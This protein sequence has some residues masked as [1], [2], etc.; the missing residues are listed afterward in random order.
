MLKQ[1]IIIIILIS[2]INC[3]SALSTHSFT[4]K[5]NRGSHPSTIFYS[6]N[7][8]IIDLSAING[9]TAQRAIF[10]PNRR[11]G[12]SGS[13][14]YYD[15][16]NDYCENTYARETMTLTSTSSD[17]LP[18]LA[19][20]YTS[21]DA[22]A[23]VQ[24]ALASGTLCTLHVATAAGLG[25]NN[26][27]L[28]LSVMVN[29]VADST[30]EQVSHA[31]ARFK[32]GDAM[33]TFTEVEPLV[34]DASIS[35][36]E[37]AA[38]Y[39]TRFTG[40][41]GNDWSGDIA[42]NRYRIYRSTS[43][44]TTE[45]AVKN[46]ELVDEIKPLSIWNWKIFGMNNCSETGTS[47]LRPYPIDDLTSGEPDM[48]IYVHHYNGS[49]SEIAYYFV[50]YTVDGAED[51]SSLI[52]G[53]NASNAVT[54]TAGHGWIVKRSET[55]Y[56]GD[57]ALYDYVKWECPPAHPFPSEPYNYRVRTPG[58]M[59]NSPMCMVALHGRQFRRR[60]W[61]MVATE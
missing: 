52:Q 59:A 60:L 11:Y 49:G 20:R 31:N 25:A 12:N 38:L 47:Y 17:T 30:I 51:F 43:P 13:N 23:A 48:G 44:L 58:S 14:H 46:A 40:K 33:I 26:E 37:F 9:A 19:P 21:F 3:F 16:Y 28:E 2:G 4:N 32:D 18:L 27:M 15:Y 22:T 42:K 29:M 41:A 35:C 8:V 5:P 54:E 39:Q 24:S 61:S 1:T 57:L 50:S 53:A 36:N 55:H 45:E 56:S 34:S 7:K 10:N 6:G